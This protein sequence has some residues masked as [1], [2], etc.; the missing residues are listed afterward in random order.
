MVHAVLTLAI[1]VWLCGRA[2]Y[3]LTSKALSSKF[4]GKLSAYTQVYLVGQFMRNL[5]I[6]KQMCK[7]RLM[8]KRKKHSVFKILKLI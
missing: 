5:Q 1:K 2:A 6:S 8:Q 4:S 7:M 3:K